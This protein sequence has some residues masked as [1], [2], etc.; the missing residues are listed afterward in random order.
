MIRMEKIG[1]FALTE[2]DVGSD[3]AA[4]KTRAVRDGD[5]WVINGEKY[6]FWIQNENGEWIPSDDPRAR[7]VLVAQIGE[8]GAEGHK[9]PGAID[10]EK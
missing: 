3:V 5:H 6:Y 8:W 9:P 10:P 2:P 4:A 1:A 7:E